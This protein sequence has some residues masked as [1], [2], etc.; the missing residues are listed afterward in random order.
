MSAPLDRLLSDLIELKAPARLIRAVADLDPTEA[1]LWV[2]TVDESPY[3]YADWARALI[4]FSEWEI[5][6]RDL[7]ISR[8]REYLSC[9]IEG[10]GGSTA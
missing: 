4:A 3:G 10:S 7:G 6:N 1:R 8:M 9:C 2:E 5:R